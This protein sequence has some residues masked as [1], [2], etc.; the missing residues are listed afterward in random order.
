MSLE[1]FTRRDLNL[2]CPS[3]VHLEYPAIRKIIGFYQDV[4]D[5]PEKLETLDYTDIQHHQQNRRI[6]DR[7][8]DNDKDQQNSVFVAPGPNNDCSEDLSLVPL[9]SQNCTSNHDTFYNI[10][11]TS[12]IND[13]HLSFTKINNVNSCLILNHLAL[14]RPEITISRLIPLWR[15]G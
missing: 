1:D 3:K 15:Q 5:N 12:D 6:P 10:A 13:I 4:K 9:S 11:N 14:L 2:K 7:N 8:R